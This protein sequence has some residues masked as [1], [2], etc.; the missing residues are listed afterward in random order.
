GWRYR[1]G[2]KINETVRNDCARPLAGGSVE[3]GVVVP[4]SKI[5]RRDS[6]RPMDIRTEILGLEKNIGT[7]NRS[8]NGLSFGHTNPHI[9]VLEW[10]GADVVGREDAWRRMA[11][12]L[13]STHAG[14]EGCFDERAFVGLYAPRRDFHA[15]GI[16]GVE[17]MQSAHVIARKA[18]R[19]F[20]RC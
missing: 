11:Y 10:D 1:N 15:K 17:V 5:S 4:R 3:F 18:A 9:D 8:M 20:S 6:G 2:G 14:P 16:C 19:V 12:E 7:E 13:N